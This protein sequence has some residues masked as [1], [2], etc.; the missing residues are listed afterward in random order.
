MALKDWKKVK[1]IQQDRWESNNDQ[2]FIGRLQNG[3]RV[4]SI[5]G[6]FADKKFKSKSQAL[7]FAKS[8]IK[9]L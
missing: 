1:G 8:Y 4:G 6:Y 3:W 5:Y 7:S 9:R 2:I